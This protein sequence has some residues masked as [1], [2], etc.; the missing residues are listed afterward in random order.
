MAQSLVG[1]HT[2]KNRKK[3]AQ[4]HAPFFL[5]QRTTMKALCRHLNRQWYVFKLRFSIVS[6]VLERFNFIEV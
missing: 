5:I 2:N 6:S 4:I 3:T 1:Q